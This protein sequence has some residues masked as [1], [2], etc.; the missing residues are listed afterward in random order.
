MSIIQH[1][2]QG[3]YTATAILEHRLRDKIE[4]KEVFSPMQ[5]ATVEG[6]GVKVNTCRIPSFRTVN[7]NFSSQFY[8][9]NS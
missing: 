5:F 4:K 8:P 9:G 7:V 3:C 6:L 1:T 2:E